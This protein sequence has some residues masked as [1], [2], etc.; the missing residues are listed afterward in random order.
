MKEILFDK[1]QGTGNDFIIIDNRLGHEFPFADQE[2]IAQWCDRKFGIGADGVIVLQN[3][4]NGMFEMVYYNSDGNLGSMCGNGG[5]C[6][7]AFAFHKGLF[8]TEFSF[9]AF[10]G[11]HQSVRHAS[12]LIDLSMSDVSIITKVEDGW[13]L[14]TGSPHIVVFTQNLDELDVFNEG[15]KIR[16]STEWFENGV[17]VNFVELKDGNLHVR[18]YERGVEEETLS[19]GTGVVAVSIAYHHEYIK[20]TGHQMVGIS[21]SG[22]DLAVGFQYENDGY[23]NI[24]LSGPAQKV[25]SGSICF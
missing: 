13:F 8:S 23:T 17:N 14:N 3:S 5:R 2:I 6:F 4:S 25:F 15:R 9:S 16:Y 1:Y 11:L 12:G 20:N 10:D 18:T 7:S 22:G 19:C 24:I 21:T